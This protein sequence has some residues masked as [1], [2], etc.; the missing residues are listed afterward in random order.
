MDLSFFA[1]LP[2]LK[3]GSC[4]LLRGSSLI[5]GQQVAEYLG[6][7]FNPTSGYENDICILIK[8]YQ[9][10]ENVP[11]IGRKTYVDI[12]DSPQLAQWLTTRPDVSIIVS[13][14]EAVEYLRSGLGIKNEIVFIPQQHCN[15]DRIKRDR[16]SVTTVGHIGLPTSFRHS[17][18]DFAK[19]MKEENMEFLTYSGYRDRQDVIDFYKKIDIQVIYRPKRIRLK[20][21]LKL[22]NAGSFEIPTIAFPEPAFFELDDAY[23][24]AKTIDEMVEWIV[25][26]RDSN[27]LYSEWARKAADAAE[28]YHIE[29]IAKL[30]RALV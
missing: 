8:P 26:L 29:N 17:H 25:K 6:A 21:T 5:R 23:I 19:R 16:T 27:D 13:C 11:R 22:V 9:N 2:F 12:V 18:E 14:N 15:Y 4:V 1:K 24:H 10:D 20:N 3:R 28:G 30:Y 7:K